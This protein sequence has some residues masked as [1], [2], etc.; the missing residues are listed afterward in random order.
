MVW[1][2]GSDVVEFLR[3]ILPTVDT[4]LDMALYSDAIFP[5][6]YMRCSSGQTPHIVVPNLASSAAQENQF[7]SGTLMSLFEISSAGGIS[8]P[9]TSL[10][11]KLK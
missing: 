8:L 1:L 11:P 7:F 4:E 2:P 10:E 6:E 9:S 3:K 5:K